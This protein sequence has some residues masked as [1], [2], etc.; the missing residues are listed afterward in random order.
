MLNEESRKY[1]S[2]A[3]LSSGTAFSYFALSR[4]NHLERMQQFSK[5]NDNNELIEYLKS[6]DEKVLAECRQFMGF[7]K[8]LGS[9]WTPTI[10][11]ADT[12]GAFITKRPEEM[13]KSGSGTAMDVLFS[14]TSRVNTSF[15]KYDEFFI[16]EMC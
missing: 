8:L 3:F 14:F 7:E 16:I 2:R 13:Y 15:L 1:F 5:I 6:A 10:E 4:A 12:N 11:S 9:A